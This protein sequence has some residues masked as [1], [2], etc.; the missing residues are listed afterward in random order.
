VLIAE[1]NDQLLVGLLLAVL[2]QDAHVSL[3]TVQSLGGF[4]E[5]AGE[6]VVHE[7]EL[8]N[9][10]QGV[11]N[12]HLALGGISRNFDFLDDLGGVVLFYVRLFSREKKLPALALCFFRLEGGNFA[13]D[14]VRRGAHFFLLNSARRKSIGSTI[15]NSAKLG[16]KLTILFV[17]LVGRSSKIN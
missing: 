13:I 5:T 12:G 3:A 6:T 9:T 14:K 2:V 8:E 10:L 16:E 4:T 11:Q 17:V 1:S 7:S 15:G